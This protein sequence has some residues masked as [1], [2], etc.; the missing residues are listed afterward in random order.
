[1]DMTEMSPE[2]LQALMQA[3]ANMVEEQLEKPQLVPLAE[4][5]QAY[6]DNLAIHEALV[7]EAC[8]LRKKLEASEK[9]MMRLQGELNKAVIFDQTGRESLEH[10]CRKHDADEG[11][12]EA[13]AEAGDVD[14]VVGGM[15]V[16][17]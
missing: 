14:R 11:K 17:L 5:M 8:E 10:E 13:E 15:G 2:L 3:R 12:T 6:A 16:Y 4:A 9:R 7:G 1:M